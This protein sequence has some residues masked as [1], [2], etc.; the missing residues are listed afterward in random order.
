M[1][2]RA[3]EDRDDSRRHRGLRETQRVRKTWENSKVVGR[4]KNDSKEEGKGLV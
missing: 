3:N 4:T 2:K 1:V